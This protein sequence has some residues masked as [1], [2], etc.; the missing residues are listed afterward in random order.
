M[1][2]AKQVRDGIAWTTS[3]RT[4]AQIVELAVGIAL[5]RLLTP[6]DFGLLEMIIVL[7]GFLALFGELGFG[8]ALV[9][10]AQISEEHVSTVFWLNVLTGVVLAALLATGAPLIADFYRD[11]R[12]APLTRVIAANFLIAPL[13]MVQVALLNRAMN[14]SVLA[15]VEVS[16]ALVSSSLALILAFKGFGTW[17]LVA[18]STAASLTTTIVL[19]SASSWRPRWLFSRTALNELVKFS[20]NL[21][22]F[23]TVNYWAR[24]SD[25]LLIGK[26]LGPAQLGIYGR[27]YATM[28]LPL[29]E[30]SSVLGRVLFPALS[31]ISSDKPQVKQMYLQWLARIAFLSFPIMGFFF[32]SADSLILTVYGSKWQSVAPILQ[33]LC[34]AGAFQSLGTTVGWIYQSQ[35]RTD[36][37][38]RWGL[39]AGGLVIASIVVGI[40]LGSIRAVA[41][42]YAITTV[43]ILT[44]PQFAIPGRLIDMTPFEVARSVGRIATCAL[45]MTLGLIALDKYVVQNWTAW[46]KLV[47][48]LSAGLGIYA[49][50]V[51][52]IAPDLIRVRTWMRT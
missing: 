51:R 1:S 12:L 2:L 32:A 3:A 7:T 48:L 15:L 37:M 16:A 35:G 10:R 46:I 42:C 25:D 52:L 17:S 31:R 13:N 34:V 9:Q 28:M 47:V 24:K 41:T 20:G 49:G 38:F 29:S 14:F 39:V 30:I 23:M 36:L 43:G 5:A 40:W 27:A 50:L 6:E 22:G 26:R 11:Q 33:I 4:L 8:A 21:L 44:Y 18:K 19:W 45:L